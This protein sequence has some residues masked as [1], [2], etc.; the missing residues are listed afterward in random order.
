MIQMKDFRDLVGR[1]VIGQDGE[2]IGTVGDVF[3]DDET[4][5]PKWLTVKTGLFGNRGS[6]VP[7]DNA[8]MRGEDILIPFDK[9]MVK[10]APNVDVDH[11]HLSVSEEAELYRFYGRDHTDTS[12]RNVSPQE[13]HRTERGSD[14]E[15]RDHERSGQS[16]TRPMEP[17][18]TRLRRYIVTEK[19]V[20][21]KVEE[22]PSTDT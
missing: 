2:K 16:E 1:T 14:E 4:G 9:G 6:F 20:T 10:D 3:T 17:G 5:Q 7:L 19:V 18:H 8:S 13:A 15:S 21:Q 11:G 12:T 22:I